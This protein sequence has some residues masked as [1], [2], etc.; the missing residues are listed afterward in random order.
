M[1]LLPAN[2]LP[3][4]AWII[5]VDNVAATTLGKRMKYC[6]LQVFLNYIV[7]LSRVTNDGSLKSS[8]IVY[9][10][11]NRFVRFV[12]LLNV[13]FQ[14]ILKRFKSKLEYFFKNNF[15]A[16]WH[17]MLNI[18]FPCNYFLLSSLQAIN[19]VFLAIRVTLNT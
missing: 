9:S 4:S 6:G 15:Y 14:K 12:L 8:L 1:Q 5:P 16:K 19:N 17:L 7:V 10:R 13:M 3:H 18:T 11:F 2:F